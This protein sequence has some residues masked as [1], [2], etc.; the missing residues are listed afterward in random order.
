MT[1]LLE[2]AFGVEINRDQDEERAQQEKRQARAQA[3][4]M[5][6][7]LGAPSE[8]SISIEQ[9]WVVPDVAGKKMDFLMDTGA[10][11]SVLNS[12]SGPLSSKSCTGTRVDGKPPTCHFTGLSLDNLNSV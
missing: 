11:Y 5:G 4:L 10:T 8:M 6:S 7:G 12:H 2:V 9:L 1:Q 3:K